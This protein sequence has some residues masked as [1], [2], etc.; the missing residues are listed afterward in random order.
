MSGVEQF[1]VH[2]ECLVQV[3]VVRR[4]SP[5][6]RRTEG[7]PEGPA[8]ATACTGRLGVPDRESRALQAP[9]EEDYAN[10]KHLIR[11]LSATRN[12]LCRLRLGRMQSY[13]E[14]HFWWRTTHQWRL[15]ASLFSNSNYSCI[16][17]WGSRTI[18]KWQLCS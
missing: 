1:F 8:Q 3:L 17:V 13:Q 6:W 12:C 18:C 7:R 14:I 16:I 10:M 15:R 5:H 11:Y 4:T 2:H 9:T